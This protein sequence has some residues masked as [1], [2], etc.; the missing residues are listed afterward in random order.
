MQHNGGS[1]FGYKGQNS[2]THNN[3]NNGSQGKRV[4]NLIIAGISIGEFPVDLE[5][6]A[7]TLKDA[8]TVTL[9]PMGCM[10]VRNY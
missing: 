8:N 4:V 6:N 9:P 7:N 2:G 3:N 10:P 5:P 1:G